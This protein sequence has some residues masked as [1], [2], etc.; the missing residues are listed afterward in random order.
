MKLKV[1]ILGSC[2]EPGARRSASPP[3]VS[4]ELLGMMGSVPRAQTQRNHCQP[5]N[6]RR[7]CR[8]CGGGDLRTPPARVGIIEIIFGS[9]ARSR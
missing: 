8:A 2:V 3:A 6:G 9:F 7:R 4:V 1:R 5:M